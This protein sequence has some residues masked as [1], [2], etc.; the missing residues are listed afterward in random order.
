MELLIF[1]GFF[2]SDESYGQRSDHA[3]PLDRV[4][5]KLSLPKNRHWHEKDS[6]IASDG[7]STLSWLGAHLFGS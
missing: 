2:G 1:D 4:C 7:L 5:A 6:E 3:N